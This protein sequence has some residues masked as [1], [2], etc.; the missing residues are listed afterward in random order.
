VTQLTLSTK[1]K[2]LL[3][4]LAVFALGG[5]GYSARIHWCSQQLETPIFQ[6]GD[7]TG[8]VDPVLKKLGEPSARFKTSARLLEKDESLHGLF[9]SSALIELNDRGLEVLIWQKNCLGST[10][11]RFGII[12]EPESQTILAVGG[13]SAFYAPVYLGGLV[14]LCQTKGLAFGD[15]GA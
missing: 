9:L 10:I 6:D 11:W 13:E 4:C 5:I 7:L 12:I 14:L 8:Q 3:S 1:A 15:P 2:L